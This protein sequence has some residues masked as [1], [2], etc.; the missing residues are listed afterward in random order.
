MKQIDV[1][2]KV[3][4]ETWEGETPAFRH[5]C[6]LAMVRE[7]EQAVKAWEASLAD[8]PTRSPEEIAV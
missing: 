4:A 8:S 2:A 6:E 7:H 1:V 5:E 3:T